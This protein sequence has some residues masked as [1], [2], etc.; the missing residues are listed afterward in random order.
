MKKNCSLNQVYGVTALTNDHYVTFKLTESYGRQVPYSDLTFALR[1]YH[2]VNS[3]CRI[4]VY[5]YIM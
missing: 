4:S 3:T 2:N 5:T 1:K